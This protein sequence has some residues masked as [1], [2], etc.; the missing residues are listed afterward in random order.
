MKFLKLLLVPL[1][2]IQFKATFK[3]DRQWIRQVPMAFRTRLAP[4]NITSIS[5]SYTNII[6][7]PVA[8][9]LKKIK[10]IIKNK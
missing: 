5:G 6:G 3:P 2:E 10:E 4:L 9:V 1:S 8:Q 7:L